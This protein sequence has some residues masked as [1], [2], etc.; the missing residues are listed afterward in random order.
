VE[1]DVRARCEQV[2]LPPLVPPGWPLRSLSLLPGWRQA[3]SLHCLLSQW[4][5]VQQQ[6]AQQSAWLSASVRWHQ[7]SPFPVGVVRQLPHC[8]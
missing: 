1:L 5:Q 3:W 8:G 7:A 6:S 2:W 4:L